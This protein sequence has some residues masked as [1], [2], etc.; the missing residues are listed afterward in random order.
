MKRIGDKMKKLLN[1]LAVLALLTV[2]AIA[3]TA[4]TVNSASAN[5]ALTQLT[6]NGSGFSP[7]STTPIVVLGTTTLSIVSASDTV[8]VATLPANEPAGSY[9]LSVQETSSGSK[10]TTFGLTIG[11]V[12]PAGP[13]GSQGPQGFT[14]ATGA[15][16][17]AGVQGPSGPTGATGPAG[18]FL[19]PLVVNDGTVNLLM[20]CSQ[21]NCPGLA[22]SDGQHLS[23]TINNAQLFALVISADVDAPNSSTCSAVIYDNGATLSASDG[24]VLSIATDSTGNVSAQ[25][26]YFLVLSVGNH[27]LF[28]RYTASE[29]GNGGCNFTGSQLSLQSYGAGSSLQNSGTF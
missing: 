16:G 17:P 8:I 26:T 15:T 24:S 28:L 19:P 12:G 2:S 20:N 23:V 11:A 18:S 1:C 4:P 6:I 25:R 27:S 10:T 5:S 14:G 7:N 9:T 13:T 21:V 3:A 29:G 22:S